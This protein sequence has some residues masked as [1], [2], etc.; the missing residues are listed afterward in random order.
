MKYIFPPSFERS[1]KKLDY[2]KRNLIIG[3]VQKFIKNMDD[4]INPG[5]MGL[6]RL[7]HNIW[8][9]RANIKDRIIFD[10]NNDTIVFVLAGNHNDISRF[11]KNR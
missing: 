9:I 10:Y 3:T 1:V 4:G 6:K 2:S 7:K 5:G 11:L 8:E